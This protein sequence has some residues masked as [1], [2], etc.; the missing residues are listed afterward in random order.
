MECRLELQLLRHAARLGSRSPKSTVLS[1]QS[2]DLVAFRRLLSHAA[3][4]WAHLLG[5]LILGLLWSPMALLAPL[6]LKI[7][8]DSAVGAQPL[9]ALFGAVLPDLI[10]PSIGPIGIAAG[11]AVAL[12]VV[13]QVQ[14]LV[15]SLL[16]TYTA[17]HLDISRNR[18]FWPDRRC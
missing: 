5:I 17:E 8:V 1:Y 16:R 2:S 11:L 12:A 7:A 13:G 14:G 4:H 15:E 6:P 10:E 9:P 3:S 18:V